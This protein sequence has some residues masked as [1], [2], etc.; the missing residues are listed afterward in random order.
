VSTATVPVI[1]TK[2]VP[3]A[4]RTDQILD[5]AVAEFAARGYAGASVADVAARAGIS[6]PL[7]YQYFGS[8]DGLYLAGL[9]RTARALLD[10]LEPAWSQEDDSVAARVRTLGALFEALAPQREA[11]R[12]LWDPSMPADGPIAEAAAGY[13]ARTAEVAA[14]GSARFLRARGL[15]SRKDAEALGAVWVGLVDSLVTWWLD[16]P[17]ESAAQMTARCARLMAA[18]LAEV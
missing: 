10:R 7:V 14:S 9:D 12:L 16:H 3:R 17:E 1:G 15:R 6:K 2:G 13:R 4:E 5:C 18:V 8:K 11:W